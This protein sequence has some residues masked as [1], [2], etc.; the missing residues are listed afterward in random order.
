MAHT[1]RFFFF[2]PVCGNSA[3][4]CTRVQIIPERGETN[5]SSEHELHAI[6]CEPEPIDSAVNTS[7]IAGK[8]RK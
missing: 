2:S 8:G 1:A 6:N 7:C 4:T 3:P 5:N